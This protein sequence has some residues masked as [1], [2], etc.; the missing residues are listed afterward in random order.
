MVIWR[1]GLLATIVAAILNAALWGL[2]R[3]VGVSLQVQ[4]PGRPEAVVGL[5]QVV[6]L[7]AVPLLVGT[8]FYTLLRRW[9]RRPFL[10]FMLLSLLIFLILLVPPFASTE[11]PG[12]RFVLI[13]MHV[14]ATAALLVGIYRAEMRRAR[15]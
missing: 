11:R 8:A 1:Y 7:T 5:L 3:A 10:I 4:P 13:L 12:T 15:P 6:L 9:T 14:V 2:A